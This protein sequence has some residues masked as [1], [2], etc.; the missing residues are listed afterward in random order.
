[1]SIYK[2]KPIIIRFSMGNTLGR[3]SQPVFSDDIVIHCGQETPSGNA[4]KNEYG[5]SLDYDRAILVN[6]TKITRNINQ[7]TIF[8]INEMP[9]PNFPYGDYRFVG[10]SDEVCGKFKIYLKKTVNNDIPVLYY[11]HTSGLICTFQINFDESSLIAFCSLNKI[12]PFNE[13]SII[14]KAEPLDVDDTEDRIVLINKE[15]VGYTG[16]S[17]S[18][19]KLTFRDYGEQAA[20]N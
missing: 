17:R 12:L 6:A 19:V 11:L 14:W 7:E 1:M 2:N 16:K 3:D 18:H 5:V 9:T 4:E 10:K 20:N 13:N 8:F 15:I